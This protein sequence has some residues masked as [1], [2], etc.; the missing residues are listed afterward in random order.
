MPTP[1]RVPRVN[2]NDDSVRVA[3]LL[4]GHGETVSPG[5]AVAEIVTDKASVVVDAEHGGHV[6]AVC[7][8]EGQIVDVGSVIAW[9]GESADARA[10]AG[11][12]VPST[13]PA[14]LPTLRAGLLL[15]EY[16]LDAASV[17]ASGA[18]LSAAD[19]EVHIARNGLT[20]PAARALDRPGAIEER[21]RAAGTFAPLSPE[22]RGMLRSVSWHRAEAVPGYVELRYDADAWARCAAAFQ[23]S[24]RLLLN[25]LLGLMAWTLV[26]AAKTRPHINSTIVDGRRYVYDHVNLG[27]TVQSDTTLYLVVIH[28]AEALGARTLCNRLTDL[29]RLAM[30]DAVGA[31]DL[32]GVTVTLSSMARWPV[33]RHIPVLPPYT[34][35]AIAHAAAS[36]ASAVLGA[37]YDHRVLTGAD[38]ASLLE[39]LGCPPDERSL[40]GSS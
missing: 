2:N 22:A 16:G 26:R 9:I 3:R 31:D 4:I 33:V 18:R 35:I 17:P 8:E 11:E 13:G 5:N 10:P 27:C 24:Q 36:G 29:Q 1:I 12:I 14:L 19:V 38:V 21:P 20:R 25:P 40:D 28:E 7:V 34:S 30:A 37:T 39:E 23:E 15:E 6:I 32:S